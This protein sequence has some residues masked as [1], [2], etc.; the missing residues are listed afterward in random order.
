MK[1]RF[2]SLTYGL[3]TISALWGNRYWWWCLSCT[4][5]H[6]TFTLALILSVATVCTHIPTNVKCCIIREDKVLQ[7]IMVI[8]ILE[9]G[10]SE[11]LTCYLSL[12]VVTHTGVSVHK[13]LNIC[14]PHHALWIR[15][16]WTLNS[17][18]ALTFLGSKWKPASWLPLYVVTL[19]VVWASSLYTA[20]SSELSHPS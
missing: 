10:M 3:C 4:T 1:H 2:T 6:Q 12:N 7:V 19:M 18:P 16:C 20:S 8:H 5:A 14:M 9:H 13:I 15:G 11:F 17:L